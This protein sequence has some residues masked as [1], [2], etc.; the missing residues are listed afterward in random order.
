[1][2]PDA[3]TEDAALEIGEI[4][5]LQAALFG[6]KR[7]TFGRCWFNSETTNQGVD[8]SILLLPGGRTGRSPILHTPNVK[9][10]PSGACSANPS[11]EPSIG[12]R[13]STLVV[14]EGGTQV[15]CSIG[16]VEINFEHFRTPFVMFGHCKGSS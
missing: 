14:E 6:I 7:D 10:V 2:R 8:L 9:H 13:G 12:I 11:S 15:V 4:Y 5:P 3:L 1:M 16:D